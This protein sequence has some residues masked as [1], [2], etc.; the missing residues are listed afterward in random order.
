MKTPCFNFY[1][2]HTVL[3]CYYKLVYSY[4]QHYYL[5]VSFNSVQ[6]GA[7]GGAVVKAL[8]Y[9]PAGRGIRFPM[10]SLEFF[11]DIILSVALWFWDRISL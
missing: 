10:V 7:R 5:V 9:K 1:G 6:L 3:L 11:S 2:R 4:H 8:S